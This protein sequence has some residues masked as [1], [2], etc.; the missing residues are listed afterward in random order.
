MAASKV[1]TKFVIILAT[2]IVALL[3]GVMT[4]GWIFI[5][6]AG[7]RNIARG[8]AAMAA[9]DQ[10]LAAGDVAG[11]NTDFKNASEYYSRAVNKD[12]T[13]IAWFKKWED[14]L[15]KW[16]P[17]N[18][19][20]FRKGY[21]I[22]YLG[23]LR[24]LSSLQPTDPK[25]Q[26]DFIAEYYSQT[27]FSRPDRAL[28]ENIIK[29]VDDRTRQLDPN[30][31][32]TKRLLRYRGM[33]RL[34]L[35]ALTNVPE[36]ERKKALVDLQAAVDA[37]KNDWEAALSIVRWH[38]AEA[39]IKSR[40]RRDADS[41]AMR[42]KAG[43]LLQAFIK[44]HPDNPEA[45][46]LAMGLANDKEVRKAVTM[47][48]KLKLLQKMR[49]IATQTLSQLAQV[50]PQDIRP[51]MVSDMI[52]RVQ[53]MVG[54]EGLDTTLSIIDKAIA[55]N[56]SS[57]ELMMQRAEVLSGQQKYQ[58]AIDQYQKIADLPNRSVS[59]EGMT[60]PFYRRLAIAHQVDECLNQMRDA[61]DDAAKTAAI[62]SAK[63]Y[64]ERLRT[65]S[66]VNSQV[67]L[68]LRE[69]KIAAAERRYEA[70]IALLSDIR[71]TNSQEDN[72]DVLIALGD[73]LA[74]YEKLIKSGYTSPVLLFRAGDLALRTSNEE[75]ALELFKQVAILSPGE[76]AIQERIE[77]CQNMIASKDPKKSFSGEDIKDPII[78][79]LLAYRKLMTEN[80]QSDARA[81]LESLYSKH[82]TDKRIVREKIQITLND[83]DRPGA[84]AI[85]DKAVKDAPDEPEWKQWRQYV[86]IEDPLEARLK[87]IDIAGLS[88]FDQQVAR[89]Q[90]FVAFGK[91]D[92]ADK[93]LA[94]AIK[95]DPARPEVIEL[96][97]LQA[98]T[99]VVQARSKSDLIAEK[100]AIDKAQALVA[101]AADL[102]T[103][104]VSGNL[105]RARLLMAQEKFRDAA[106][107]L[108]QVVDKIPT[109]PVAWRLLG[110]SLMDSG[111]INDGLD[112]F[113]HAYKGRPA[114]LEIAKDYCRALLRANRGK[115][116]L[117][118]INP[119]T[120]VLSRTGEDAESR[121]LWLE[122]EALH[123]TP[124]EGGRPLAIKARR[125]LMDR[126]P[127]DLQNAYSLAR[128]LIQEERWDEVKAV[129]AKLKANPKSKPLVWTRLTA[130]MAAA[131]GKI[132]E[133]K[134]AY[135]DILTSLGDK[136][137]ALQY[138]AYAD[139]LVMNNLPDDALEAMKKA[140]PLQTKEH[141]AD[142]QLADFL[143]NGAGKL[144][145]NAHRAE[146]AGKLDVSKE[147]LKH[148]DE[149]LHDA[150]EA[151][152]AVIKDTTGQPDY[153]VIKRLVETYIRLKRFDDAQNL[154][155][156][157]VKDA[158]PSFKM[159]EDEQ[160]LLLRGTILE[161]RGD[162][163]AARKLY[164][165]AIDLF[166]GD[167]NP[168]MARTMLNMKD[169]NA[170]PEII[171]DVTKITQIQP[172]NQVAWNILF[173]MY[174]KRGQDA[175]AFAQLNKAVEAN[176]SDPDL[177]M[178][179][180]QRLIS[181]DRRD[182]ALSQAIRLANVRKTDPNICGV[183]AGL[184]VKMGKYREA[185]EFYKRL[186]EMPGMDT[187][188]MKAAYL[189]SLLNRVSPPQDPTEVGALLRDVETISPP[190]VK[191]LM[192]R[193]RAQAFLGEYDEATKLAR[194]AYKL[195]GDD[196]SMV[197]AWFDMCKLMYYMH[198]KKDNRLLRD[199]PNGNALAV[200]MVFTSMAG[201]RPTPA[202]MVILEAPLKRAGGTSYEQLG[203]ELDALAD[204]IKDDPFAQV[205]MIRVLNR[206]Q[207]EQSK[208][209]EQVKLLQDGIK[210]SPNDL[211]FNNNLAYTLSVHLKK[212][213][214]ALPYATL[215][216]K[217]DPK[218]SAIQDTMGQI[219]IQLNMLEEAD[220]A[221]TRAINSAVTPDEI[222]PA[223]IHM[224]TLKVL[225]NDREWA[226]KCLERAQ[227]A[228]GGLSSAEMKAILQPDIDALTLKLK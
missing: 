50:K 96:S 100:A 110:A 68:K 9:G 109:H 209:E 169:E 178:Q 47:E 187:V 225:Q 71:H 148:S 162:P 45:L 88:P 192:L 137:T 210:L 27:K 26:E 190:S 172:N 39:D 41:D 204:K 116:A 133:G 3:G 25:A 29:E 14:A 35:T 196:S 65:I 181:A 76:P 92:E 214:D 144:K 81:L 83:G 149:F 54:K 10:K 108:K 70:A 215:A 63:K 60:L 46:I 206:F 16:T 191:A 61:K 112:A 119:R 208:F 115:D 19:T 161:Q 36:D 142:R 103:D 159:D 113:D 177:G 138:L 189:D 77:Q 157:M 33:A 173:E 220:K 24:Q 155:D 186:R 120:G 34:N 82:P 195:A 201:T 101:K 1:N 167:V 95:I 153:P 22:H 67:E 188:E 79:D 205:E 58:E 166:P 158:P 228:I 185:A 150:A 40:D 217:L 199:L 5:G 160:V 124:P 118:I 152:E 105:Y 226:K 151:Y 111:Q 198:F 104:Q 184:C 85:I 131:Q 117:A 200:K 219:C 21:Y 203:K 6:Q 175:T 194:D 145:D 57:V 128:L 223:N 80:N 4:L 176:P 129:I 141:E 222:V 207:Y 87:M 154:I 146:V 86:E 11:A 93:A 20:E 136:V 62:A 164:D 12:Q 106:A 42:N 73:A 84:L 7:P 43:E 122:L 202:M 30:S 78:R 218:N 140:R 99:A 182:E 72:P 17:D 132:D 216:A 37:D 126:S 123:G 52:Y 163:R 179:L 69:A 143:F 94:E 18:E 8:D 130:D 59:L 44:E 139:W 64:L 49:P 127:D 193:A 170:F 147:I 114:D 213:K 183:T 171:A 28:L 98:V 224:G 13:K 48:D 125:V 2:I 165:K 74:I 89:Y 212:P 23:I 51:G 156:K 91:Q 15:R 134:Q 56:P 32:Q 90:A 121:N 102:N 38:L 227:K 66:D 211:E 97:F 180:V 221:L 75:R 174:A 31:P 55:A 53:N 107:V 135:I 168:W 197:N